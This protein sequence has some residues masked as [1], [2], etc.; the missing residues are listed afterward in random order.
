MLTNRVGKMGVTHQLSSRL[1]SGT[2]TISPGKHIDQVL[3][4]ELVALRALGD[5]YESYFALD[6]RCIRG[7][8]LT[9]IEKSGVCPRIT[10]VPW[11]GTGTL[12]EALRA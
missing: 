3:V 7:C 8:D 2:P 4:L 11:V 6:R 5:W 10:P 12:R 9:L 1:S